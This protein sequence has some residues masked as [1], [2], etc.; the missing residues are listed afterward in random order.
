MSYNATIPTFDFDDTA[1]KTHIESA[2]IPT[3]LMTV[4]HLSQDMSVLTEAW[5]PTF[6]F[7]DVVSRLTESEQREVREFCFRKLTEL[8][9][10]KTPVP[11]K[12]TYDQLHQIATWLIGPQIDPFLPLVSE[13]LVTNEQDLRRPR[14]TKQQIA[15][16]RNFHI[17]IIG[18]GASG[19]VAALRLKQ[20]G[21]PFVIYEKNNEVGGTWLENTYPGCRV[22]INS[23]FYS[24]SFARKV[25]SDYFST[26]QDIL[27]YLKD[28]ARE[29]G[30]YEHI[31]FN[32]EVSEMNWDESR[33]VWDLKLRCGEKHYESQSNVVVSAVG[34]LNRPS[35]PDIPG[36]ETFKGPSFHSARWN[37]EIDLTGKRVGVIGT[38]ASALQFIPHVARKAAQLTI[39]ARTTNWLL[40]MPDLH[41]PVTESTKW[42]HETIPH[43]AMWYRASL[44]LP[45]SVGVMDA[46]IVDPTYPPTEVAVSA[47][48]DQLR[49]IITKWM[50][51]QIADRPDLRDV[52]IPDSPIGGKRII[53]DNG[54]WIATLKRDNVRVERSGISA[55]T[56]HGIVCENGTEHEFDVIIYGTGFEASRFL[57]PMKVTGR[58]GVDLHT[59]WNGDAR[60]YMGTAIPGFPNLFCMY[61][62]NTNLVVNANQIMYS[63]LSAKYIVDAARLLLE[64]GRDAVEV[65]EDVFDRFNER[66]DEANAMRAWGFSK[67]RSWYKNS[68][69]RIAQNFPFGSV[70]FWRRTHEVVATDYR[71]VDAPRD[72]IHPGVDIDARELA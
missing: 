51:P 46:V 35:I 30:L 72:Q 68:K 11:P 38:G 63:E 57:M 65:R 45:Q 34:Q 50:E 31:R 54:T 15:P 23:F 40:P 70:E 61:G 44:A 10:K 56:E 2:E 69:G 49:Q 58:D 39:F 36:L 6:E 17:A 60:S 13:E 37:H 25:W 62:P 14:W 27:G 19:L 9:D 24:F 47:K 64:S 66:I 28:V 48:N 71:F 42:L 22:D 21:V 1:L 33:C 43:Y 32:T 5:R 8:R 18:A 55:I 7:G 4:A 53:R 12:P 52:V 59:M 3:L 29:Y 67:V 41:Y 26:S 16:D 20:A